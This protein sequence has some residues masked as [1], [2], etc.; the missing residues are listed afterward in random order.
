MPDT[1]EN[2][3]LDLIEWLARTEHTHQETFDAWRASCPRLTGGRTLP[4]A[5]SLPP[6][7]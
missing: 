2:L 7:P 6:R 1:V 4:S 5:D 3:I